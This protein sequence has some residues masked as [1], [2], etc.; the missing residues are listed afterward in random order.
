MSFIQIYTPCVLVVFAQN[1]LKML[2][3]F[4]FTRKGWYKIKRIDINNGPIWVLFVCIILITVFS[5]RSLTLFWSAA[6]PD[7]TEMVREAIQKTAVICY[8]LEGSYPPDIDYMVKYYGLVFDEDQYA[9]RYE[10][11]ASNIMPEIEVHER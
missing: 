5:L 8:A 9:Y 3:I 7:R 10:V 1:L 11:F 2:R 6:D 4:R